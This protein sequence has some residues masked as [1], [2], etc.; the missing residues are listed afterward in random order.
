MFCNQCG[1][2]LPDNA[3]FCHACGTRAFDRDAS[4]A[5]RLQASSSE[6]TDVTSSRTSPEQPGSTWRCASC[7]RLNRPGTALCSCGQRRASVEA[8]LPTAPPISQ[9]LPPP[10]TSE[11]FQPF[12]AIWL[13]PRETIRRIIETNT[14]Q[15][16]VGLICLSSFFNGLNQASNRN[17]GDQIPTWAVLLVV[18]ALS[19][20]AIPIAYLGAGVARWTAAKLGGVAS[21]KEVRAVVAWSSVPM[22]QLSLIVWPLQLLLFGDENFRSNTPRIDAISPTISAAILSLGLA[23][24]V[25]SAVVGIKCFAEVN[26]F[27]A[28]KAVRA[29]LM[30]VGVALGAIIVV[31]LMVTV[32]VAL[33]QEF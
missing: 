15:H 1:S 11:G 25:W 21:E 8:V 30:A 27:S 13:K 7:R 10:A 4:V 29:G 24:L 18:A 17:M 3:R 6:A 9:S 5:P 26:R 28:W 12:I 16:V 31:A 14:H 33:F 20:V 2:A 32:V 19:P 23:V 22:I